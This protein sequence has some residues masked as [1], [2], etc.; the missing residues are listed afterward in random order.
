MLIAESSLIPKNFKMDINPN[1]NKRKLTLSL[2]IFQF[3]LLPLDLM[4]LLYAV[5]SL[6]NVYK[7]QMRTFN[8]IQVSGF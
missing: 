6:I 3:L 7:F 4:I 2:R 8:Q 1:D 5:T